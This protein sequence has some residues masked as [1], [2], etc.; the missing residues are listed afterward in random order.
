MGAPTSEIGYTSATTRRGDHEIYMCMWWPGMY[1]DLRNC[2][3]TFFSYFRKSIESFD[4]L[5]ELLT[6]ILDYACLCHHKRDWQ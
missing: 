4:K 5:L 1:E 2:R 3:G 6:I